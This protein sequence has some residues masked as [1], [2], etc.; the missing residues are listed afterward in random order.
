MLND[1]DPRRD[2]VYDRAYKYVTYTQYTSTAD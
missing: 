2:A 1:I